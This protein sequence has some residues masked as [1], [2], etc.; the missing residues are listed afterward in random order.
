MPLI[1]FRAIYNQVLCLFLCAI[2]EYPAANAAAYAYKLGI[3]AGKSFH[4][5]HVFHSQF[6]SIHINEI[7]RVSNVS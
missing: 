5:F 7:A 1:A 3:L 2:E 4:F 6:A